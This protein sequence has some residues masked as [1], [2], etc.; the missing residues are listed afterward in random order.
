MKLS[1]KRY[2]FEKKLNL[3]KNLKFI[4]KSNLLMINFMWIHVRM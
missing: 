2:R 1:F 4:V 3:E